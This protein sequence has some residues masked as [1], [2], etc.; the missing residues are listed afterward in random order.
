MT[1]DRNFILY[2]STQIV[3][4]LIK[5]YSNLMAIVEEQ[6]KRIL[7]LEKRLRDE[8]DDKKSYT[9]AMRISNL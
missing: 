2:I 1:K 4:K 9:E 7:D 6:K 5:Q 3:Q 8:S